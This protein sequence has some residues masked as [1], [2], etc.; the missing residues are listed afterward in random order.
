M[1]DEPALRT[2]AR[3][4]LQRGRIPVRRPDRTW[5]GLGLGSS[6]CVICGNRISKE[7]SALEIEFDRMSGPG[8]DRFYIHPRCFAAWEFERTKLG[9]MPSSREP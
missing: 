7:E 8:M 9:R 2:R 4:A 3:E 1:P 6:D 5:G